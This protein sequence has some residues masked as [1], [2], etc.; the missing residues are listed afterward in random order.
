MASTVQVLMN[1]ITATTA[2]KVPFEL[3]LQDF[4]GNSVPQLWIGGTLAAGDDIFL[5]TW[6]GGAWVANG[7]IL[8][9]TVFRYSLSAIGKYAI[10]ATLAA[11]GPITVELHTT[12]LR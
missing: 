8:D 3:T 11:A 5:W 7:T 1:A 10:T 9:E 4:Q 2:T 6:V 12:A